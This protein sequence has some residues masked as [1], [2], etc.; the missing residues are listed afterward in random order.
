M[1]SE[2]TGTGGD[3]AVLGHTPWQTVGPFFHLALP[4]LDGGI[5]TRSDTKGERINVIGRV[6]DADGAPVVD[7]MI[8]VWQANAAGRYRHPDDI[9]SELAL[10]DGFVG[11]GRVPTDQDGA[12]RLETVR[13]GLIPGPGHRTQA[14][15]IAVGVFGRGLLKRLVT[16]LYFADRPEN[17]DDP[18][19][20]LVPEE[21]RS[22]LIANLEAPGQYR[23]D[24]S[25][26]GERETVFFDV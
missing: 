13:P 3:G 7:A 16:R 2:K 21:R 22:T 1:D 14:P 11:F 10:D 4:W 8:E 9:R 24:I 19:L 26:Q 15:H 18:I 6:T 23:F 12:F 25:L 20:S 17:E 5:L